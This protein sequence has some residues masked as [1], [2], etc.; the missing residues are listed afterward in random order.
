[1][2]T[3]IAFLLLSLLWGSSY[4]FIRIGD[5]QL[6][7]LALVAL[8]LL[9]G[10]VVLASIAAARR[11]DLHLSRRGVVLTVIVATMNTSVPF[12]LIAW[13]EKTVPSGLAS[14]L[15]STVPIFSVLIAG[16]VLHD[17]PITSSRLGGVTMGFA[18]I[19][20]LLSRD[21]GQ[22]GIHWSGVMGQ[23]AIV[24]A[25]VCYAGMAVFTRRT[26]RGVPS[27]TIATYT[28]CIA[29]AEVV[30]LSLVFSP[31]PVGSLHLK[32]LFSVV[33]L[34]AL[35][36]AIAYILAYYI[37]ASW[38]AAR[39]TFVA[40]MLPMVG[41]ALGAI[42]LGETLAWRTLAGSA[43]VILGIVLA[44]IPGRSLSRQEEVRQPATT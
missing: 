35:G 20:L 21:L 24:L 5:E 11:Q 16:A 30:L 4:L 18:G 28:L 8:R 36:S 27:M 25:A 40:Y 1:M 9:I 23:G 2:T 39:Y 44:S 6:T 14:V 42:Y 19:L 29:A 32:T 37:L 7:P 22:S 34:G 10:A 15:N 38:G 43:L 17:E 41:L 33:W 13:G 3:W 26:L 31:P 12:L